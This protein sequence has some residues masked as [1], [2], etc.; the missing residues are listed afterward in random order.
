MLYLPTIEAKNNHLASIAVGSEHAQSL[1]TSLITAR[2]IAI[3]Q[4]SVLQLP[5]LSLK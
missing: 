4:I 2:L 5:C 1:L 3:A